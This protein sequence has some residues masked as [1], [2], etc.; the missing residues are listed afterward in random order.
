MQVHE[1]KKKEAQINY[2]L[3][4]FLCD[5]VHLC[6]KLVHNHKS[7]VEKS[8]CNDQATDTSSAVAV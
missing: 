7:Q 8:E 1:I 6:T 5:F 2:Y 3:F 4:F